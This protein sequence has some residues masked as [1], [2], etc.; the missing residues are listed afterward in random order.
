MEKFYAWRK[1][2]QKKTWKAK[3]ETMTTMI[4]LII[5]VLF[6]FWNKMK[7]I[8]TAIIIHLGAFGILT[9]LF[10]FFNNSQWMEVVFLSSYRFA[11]CFIFFISREKC[12]TSFDKHKY[13]FL[14]TR[15][16][17]WMDAKKKLLTLFL[18]FLCEKKKLN[19]QNFVL[20]KYQ[21]NPIQLKSFPVFFHSI[22]D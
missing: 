2:Q 3:E 7:V 11:F 8:C 13:T 16:K 19:V 20:G 5:C 1:L 15:F 14:H 4:L 17:V 21:R 18:F 6:A 9:F 10:S 12:V 22:R